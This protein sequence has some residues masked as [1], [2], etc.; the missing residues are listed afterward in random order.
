MN[1]KKIFNKK[2]QINFYLFI[3]F[4]IIFL[5][6]FVFFFALNNNNSYFK[7]ENNQKIFYV[8]P[9]DKDGKKITNID[10]KS[11]HIYQNN[12]INDKIINNENLEY[13]IQLFSS[14]NYDLIIEKLDFFIKNGDLDKNKKK[15][16]IKDFYILIFNHELGKEYFLLYKNFAN[17]SLAQDYCFNF[18]NLQQKCIILNAQNL[19]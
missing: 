5:I 1:K 16:Q 17:R 12:K 8:I 3:F 10:K 4:F 18:I 19:D 15:L 2:K 14:Y 7:I 11:L 9:N 13:S 6:I